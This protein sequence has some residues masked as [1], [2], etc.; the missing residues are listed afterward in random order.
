MGIG[1]REYMRPGS[2]FPFPKV[3]VIP[4]IIGLNIIVYLGWQFGDPR[5]MQENFLIS[6]PHL[7]SGKF[8]TLLT[9]A[10][11]HNRFFH[12]FLNMFILYGFGR[13]LEARWG[14]RRFLF[15]YLAAC[16]VSSAAHPLA[17]SLGWPMSFALG[18]SGAISALIACFAIYHPKA[19]ILLFFILPMPAWFL[20]P[21]GVLFDVWGLIEQRSGGGVGIG[22]AVHLG[23]SA[24]G[25]FYV[26]VIERKRI[27]LFGG[28]GSRRP[29]GRILHLDESPWQ[30]SERTDRDD[31]EERRLDELLEKVSRG[32]LDSLSMEERDVLE[33]I[34]ARR[35]HGKR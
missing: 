10:F 33:R 35:R 12:I 9:A 2:R 1:D 6:L 29:R 21:I 18:A 11:S 20:V 28:G 15:V 22:H 32:G 7:Q 3:G 34:S 5:F 4:A 25:M 26:L 31:P 23:G 19:K 27:A 13:V 30:V 8:W 14:P 16:L 24:F 17:T